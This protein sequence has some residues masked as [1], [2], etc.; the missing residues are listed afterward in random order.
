MTAAVRCALVSYS[1]KMSIL[2]IEHG[3][4]GKTTTKFT[5]LL[6]L[7][8]ISDIASFSLSTLPVGVGWRRSDA[9]L[10]ESVGRNDRGRSLVIWAAKASDRN[11]MGAGLLSHQWSLW[12]FMARI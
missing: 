2:M 7:S 4:L 9:A 1:I 8:V 11:E 3:A 10:A 5:M 12:R 6:R